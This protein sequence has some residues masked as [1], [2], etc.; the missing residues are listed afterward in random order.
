MAG[1]SVPGASDL[2]LGS[3]LAEQTQAETE[4][5][6]KKRLRAAAASKMSGV[7]GASSLGLGMA[8]G[9]TAMGLSPGG[10]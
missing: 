10:Y 9:A 5:E 1:M 3:N 4:E 2:G 6:R 8:G 7:P